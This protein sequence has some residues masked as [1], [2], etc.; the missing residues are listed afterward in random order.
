[1]SFYGQRGL[2]R[3]MQE[4]S[5]QNPG[6]APKFLNKNITEGEGGPYVCLLVFCAWHQLSSQGLT[7][8]GGNYIMARCAGRR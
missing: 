7:G 3:Q 6:P 1:M 5:S 4:R 8:T 2:T